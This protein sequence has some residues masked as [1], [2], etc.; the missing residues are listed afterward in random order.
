MRRI[1]FLII[2][3]LPM[4]A[5]SQQ[6][7]ER[8]VI[9]TATGAY[10]VFT[11]DSNSMVI[12]LDTADIELMDTE[13]NFFIQ[14][15]KKWTLQFFTLSFQNPNNNDLS[16]LDNQKS[17]LFQ[18]M[19]YELEYIKNE[20]KMNIENEKVF[21]GPLGNKHF[22]LWHF[23]TPDLPAVQ[24]QLYMTAICFNSFLNINVPLMND[25]EYVDG[26]ELLNRVG[27]NLVLHDHP[28]DI[29]E[30]YKKVNGS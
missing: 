30:M 3:T 29:E 16:N 7:F 20:I 8:A 25:Q 9:E 2:T 28:I 21:W 11:N 10:I 19:N 4:I 12:Y 1:L 22:L 13:N 27:R 18:Y 6:S 23:D 26:V 15:D 14:V 24:K 17:S 5:L